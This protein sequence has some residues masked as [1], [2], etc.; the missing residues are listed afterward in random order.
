VTGEGERMNG[1]GRSA[2]IRRDAFI[3]RDCFPLNF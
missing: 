1:G 2:H 3:A